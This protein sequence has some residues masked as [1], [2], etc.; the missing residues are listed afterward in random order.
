MLEGDKLYS[1]CISSQHHAI[2]LSWHHSIHQGV[3]VNETQTLGLDEASTPYNLPPRSDGQADC[4]HPTSSQESS[5]LPQT[6]GSPLTCKILPL[7]AARGAN[8]EHQAVERHPVAAWSGERRQGSILFSGSVS[9]LS[10]RASE[11]RGAASQQPISAE[12]RGM[13]K[14]PG[15]GSGT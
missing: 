15:P 8:P 12:V 4:Q 11:H 1:G 6:R 10:D 13:C 2:S 5:L 3:S 14:V 7:P 9:P